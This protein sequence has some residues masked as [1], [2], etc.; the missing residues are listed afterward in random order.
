MSLAVRELSSSSEQII[1][2]LDMDHALLHDDALAIIAAA[3]GRGADV[4]VGSMLCMHAEAQQ[5]VDI[6]FADC[7]SNRRDGGGIF[8]HPH[9][10]RKKL[11]DRLLD[12]D[13]CDN[14][15]E[16]FTVACDLTYM[17]PII[18]MASNP[19]KLEDQLYLY[20][21]RYSTGYVEKREAII[22]QVVGKPPYSRC[23]TQVA[24][25]GDASFRRMTNDARRYAEQKAF[26]VGD[27]L[28]RAGYTVITGGM[29]GVMEWVCRGAKA[30]GGS[31]VG[32]LLGNDKTE[33]NPF[34]DV[35]IP[36]GLGQACNALVAQSDALVCI[37]GGSGTVSELMHA[38]SMNRPVIVFRGLGATGSYADQAVD[39]RRSDVVVGADNEDDVLA[40]LRAAGLY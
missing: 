32:I 16:P 22:E 5:P 26:A 10:F 38:W 23:R 37:G 25:C 19:V 9:S 20:E 33:A 34:V 13:L 30:A 1:V 40:A 14:Q 11:F 3:H 4:T 7:R 28:A 6:D 35:P 29:G 24:V 2:T 36:T 39:Y 18:E 12:T 27:A 17:I 8:P 31:T 15:D 21:P